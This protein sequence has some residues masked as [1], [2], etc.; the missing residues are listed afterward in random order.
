MTLKFKN[1]IALFNTLAVAFTT[2]LVFLTIYMVVYTTAY[3]HLDDDILIEKEEVFSNL[4]W[5]R[6]S[7]IINKMPEW[8]EAEH[9]QVEVNP[10]FLQITD[11]HG[12]VIFRST[13]L[14]QEQVLAEPEGQEQVYYDGLIRNKKIRL[15]QFPIKNNDNKTIGELTIAISEE[16]SFNIL[17]NLI[18]VLLISFPLVLLIQFLASSVA[19][20]KAIEPVHQ[21][22]QTASKI[23]DS[24]ISTR[25]VLPVH[26]DELFELTKTINELLTR[27]EASLIQQ[28]QFTSDASHEIR[29]PLSAIRGTLEVLI[30][31]QREPQM[32]EDKISG[33][34]KEVDRL[35]MLLDQLLQLA[36]IE[37]NKAVAR[38]ESIQLAEIIS[39]SAEKWNY[40][41]T[42]KKINQTL[43]IPENVFVTAD[44]I[45]LELILDNILNNAIKYGKEHGNVFVNWNEDAK[46]LVIQDDGIGISPKDLPNIFNRFY[47]ADE[48]RSSLVK[49]N[50]LG[51]SIVK[52]LADLQG[53][54][55]VA[56]STPNKG[57]TFSLRFP[58]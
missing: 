42:S 8:D 3:A 7:I 48:S 22:M 58:F 2:A 6:D 27:I 29:T 36:R 10:T 18:Y 9:S 33:I 4:D 23:S 1:R 15:G 47:R 57:S 41:A 51:L 43:N 25:L 16:E 55:L 28:K 31:K 56:E 19:A 45:F 52:K 44:R 32:Y 53:I 37:S 12:K 50:G 49:G 14:L 39:V 35:D 21:L 11:E 5:N 20:S 24:N 17:N 38:N 30:R 13:N 34:I 54:D 40:L 46:T 26:K